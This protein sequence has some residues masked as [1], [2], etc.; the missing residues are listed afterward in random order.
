LTDRNERFMYKTGDLEVVI[1]QCKDCRYNENKPLSC[2]KY[3]RIPNGTRS[4]K[5]KCPYKETKN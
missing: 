5:V 1:N 4:S 2:Q 3:V